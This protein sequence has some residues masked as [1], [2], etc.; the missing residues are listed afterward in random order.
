MWK[1]CSYVGCLGTYE[2]IRG[3]EAVFSPPASFTGWP[4]ETLS[5]GGGANVDSI[6][7]EITFDINYE[8]L[9]VAVCVDTSWPYLL[10]KY[11]DFEHL[12]FEDSQGTR[13]AIGAEWDNN[14]WTTLSGKLI[15][16]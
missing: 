16:F 14:N 2:E 5:F 1:G 12:R 11:N 10:R 8:I 7:E 4:D 9:K 6:Y 15:G 13:Y 3:F